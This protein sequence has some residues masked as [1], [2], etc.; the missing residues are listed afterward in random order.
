MA[1]TPAPQVH[2]RRAP[3]EVVLAGV[4]NVEAQSVGAN[5]M[6]RRLLSHLLALG[7]ALALG[8]ALGALFLATRGGDGGGGRP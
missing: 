4:L 2:D 6:E 5:T 3:Y 8:R 7:G 1:A